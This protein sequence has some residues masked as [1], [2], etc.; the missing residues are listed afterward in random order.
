MD[1][2]RSY[3]VMDAWL[4]ISV[5]DSEHSSEEGVREYLFFF[6]IHVIFAYKKRKIQF[7]FLAREPLEA[8]F[9]LFSQYVL[10]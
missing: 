2:C 5:G 9:S 3:H 4:L 6:R 1:A 7:E 10:R 8:F